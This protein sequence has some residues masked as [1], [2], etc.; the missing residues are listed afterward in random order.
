MLKV[1]QESVIFI[2]SAGSAKMIHFQGIIL[3]I[4]NELYIFSVLEWGSWLKTIAFSAV[5]KKRLG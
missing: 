2:R 1:L 5:F 3:Y 4:V